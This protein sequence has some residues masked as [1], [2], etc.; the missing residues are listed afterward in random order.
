LL[1]PL[2]HLI[3][4]LPLVRGPGM[5]DGAGVDAV[6]IDQLG[7]VAHPMTIPQAQLQV[8]VFGGGEV[9]PKA[10]QLLEYGGAN[11]KSTQVGAGDTGL[12]LFGDVG[13]LVATLE[14]DQGAT[15]LV[16]GGII[17]RHGGKLGVLLQ[18]GDLG[19]QAGW[20]VEIIGVAASHEFP[21]G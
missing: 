21:P 9:G 11:Q 6:V 10:P 4:K 18:P 1:K 16:N 17:T 5:G 12:Q 20:G 15:P 7:A 8:N 14:P 13:L 3:K 2:G 19:H